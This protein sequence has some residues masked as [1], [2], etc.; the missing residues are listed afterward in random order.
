M[1]TVQATNIIMT[2]DNGAWNGTFT[3]DRFR[4]A[5]GFT[6]YAYEL[7]MDN[8]T[9]ITGTATSCSITVTL[10]NGSSVQFATGTETLVP[11]NTATQE[12]RRGTFSSVTA[13][14]AGTQILLRFQYT[15]NGTVT[16][17]VKGLSCKVWGYQS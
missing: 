14:T 17:N 4:C 8:G 6:P 3:I 13:Q 1:G 9:A 2:P 10:L 12:Y 16:A 11:L 7:S 15:A 5:L